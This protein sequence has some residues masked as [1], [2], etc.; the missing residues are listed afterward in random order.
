MNTLQAVV[1]GLLQGI[2]EWLPVSSEGVITLTMTQLFGESA[3]YSVSFAIWLHLGTMFAALV[4]FR[5]DF[6]KILRKLPGY[7]SS[8]PE[9]NLFEDEEKNLT[10]FIILATCVTGIFGGL[11]YLFGLKELATRPKLFT[12]MMGSALLATGILRL[13]RPDVQKVVRKVGF[14]DS[15]FT[16]FLQS[17]S[18]LPG[19]SRS[20][21]TM[22]AL[23]YRRFKA[24][25]ALRLSFLLSVPAVLIA[26]IGLELTSG[27]E[28]STPFIF[29]SIVSFLV[30]Y[31]SISVILKV[32]ERLEVAYLCFLLSALTFS[33]LLL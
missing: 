31:V 10:T 15:I 22:F 16:G 6:Y 12:A 23:F 5:K 24:R 13:Y 26:N 17:F 21:T 28:L 27:F 7:L 19:I 29:G 18:V 11:I 32:A 8:I 2:F 33:T 14:G 9:G 30:G 1:L 4:Y 3:L 25:E 20:G